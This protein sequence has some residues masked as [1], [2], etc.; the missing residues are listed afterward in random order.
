[1]SSSLPHIGKSTINLTHD[2][3]TAMKIRANLIDVGIRYF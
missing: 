3:L 1:M 2:D